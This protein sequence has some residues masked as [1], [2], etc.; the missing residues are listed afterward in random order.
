MDNI[1]YKKRNE[2][3]IVWGFQGWM[4]D[5]PKK[6]GIECFRGIERTVRNSTIKVGIFS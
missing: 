4:A 1:R 3:A 5:Y 6:R 2:S